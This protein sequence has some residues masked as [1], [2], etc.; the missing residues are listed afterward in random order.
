MS[1]GEGLYVWKQYYHLSLRSL[2]NLSGCTAGAK[3][4]KR[5]AS[6]LRTCVNITNCAYNIADSR[7]YYIAVN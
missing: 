5:V 1:A 2:Q 3:L 7:I 4:V 6:S